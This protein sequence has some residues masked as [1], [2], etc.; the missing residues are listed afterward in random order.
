MS[1]NEDHEPGQ[2]YQVKAALETIPAFDVVGVSTI[3]TN[4]NDRA[5]EDINALW[6]RFFAEMAL[7]PGNEPGSDGSAPELPFIYAVYSDYEGDHTKPYRVTIGYKAAS[8]APVPGGQHKVTICGGDYGILSAA[9]PQPQSLFDSWTA[10]WASDLDRRFDTDFELYG[11]RFF[12]PGLHEILL[13]VG[14]KQGAGS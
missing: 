13:H 9:G 5:A 1:A 3:T 10:I 8:G 14:L 2:G 4:E 6:Q 12:A 11:P 7:P